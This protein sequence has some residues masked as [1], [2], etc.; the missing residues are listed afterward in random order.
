MASKIDLWFSCGSTYS[1]LL[2]QRLDAI[3]ASHGVEFALHPFYLGAILNEAGQWPYQP[4]SNKTAY[5]WRDLDRSARALGLTPRMPAPYPVPEAVF[6]NQVAHVALSQPW[7]RRFL[8]NSFRLW[9][10]TGE[11]PGSEANLQKA[12]ASVDQDAE[13][14][15]SRAEAPDVHADLCA[16]TDLA[17]KV[18]V[19]GAPTFVLG[20]ELYWGND[21]VLDAI[22]MAKGCD[23]D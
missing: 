8:T 2:F 14:I 23:P 12:L 15:R 16:K 22:K 11:M 1:A 5:M 7:G 9:F 4:G 3:E 20:E 17:R 6:A 13:D 18:G 10:E 19:F 21:R